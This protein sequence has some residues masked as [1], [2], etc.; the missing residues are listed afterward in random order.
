MTAGACTLGEEKER[1]R[2]CSQHKRFAPHSPPGRV[3]GC[4]GVH[5]TQHGLA[6]R[7]SFL[8]CAW[9]EVGEWS[10]GSAWAP[11]FAHP[12]NARAHMHARALVD[13]TPARHT[14]NWSWF[15]IYKGSRNDT[16]W[17]N[18]RTSRSC[19]L[20]VAPRTPNRHRTRTALWEWAWPDTCVVV[21]RRVSGPVMEAV[22]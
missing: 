21:R 3:T 10:Q 15:Q 12:S 16:V 14:D 19:T 4:E 13:G 17:N 1:Q 2:T 9:R 6:R 8:D 22:C 7:L 5:A 18:V 20:A 11:A